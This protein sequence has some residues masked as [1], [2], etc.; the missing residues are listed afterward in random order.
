MV[1]VYIGIAG[2]I[3]A[4]AR[5]YCSYVWLASYG[6]QYPWGTLFCNLLGTFLLS[7][8]AF[9]FL[10]KAYETFKQVVMIG[11]LGSFTTF[12]AFSAEMFNFSQQNL[13]ID[14]L[15]Y[16]LV[17]L[18]GGWFLTWFGY[19]LALFRFKKGDCG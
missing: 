11:F 13:I 12:S 4:L 14:G 7:L 6:N 3:G 17:S 2:S 9:G 18:F 16:L 19:R 10:K 15:S 5:Y 1:A 8:L